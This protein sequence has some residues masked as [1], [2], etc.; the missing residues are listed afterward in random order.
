MSKPTVQVSDI[1]LRGLR[2]TIFL[3]LAAFTLA[4][5]L[6][7]L[8]T[9]LILFLSEPAQR[10]F[11]TILTGMASL[12]SFFWAPLLVFIF[13]DY[14]GI[15]PTFDDGTWL[16]WCL[17]LFA[18]V[19]RPWATLN[20]VLYETWSASMKSRVLL[21]ARA[22]GIRK[23]Q[24]VFSHGLRLSLVTFIQ[25]AGQIFLQVIV[26]SFVVEILLGINGLAN[27]LFKGLS[28]RDYTVV[29]GISLTYCIFSIVITQTMEI[30]S[31]SFDPRW[32]LSHEQ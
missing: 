6:S 22:K 1:I 26:G 16:A 24:I 21:F 13:G 20:L 14:L 18:I 25:K 10:K 19:V 7:L 23:F 29:V 15:F 8:V 28:Q 3:N 32:E 11:V 27:I 30:L 31:R 2:T 17:P 9:G 4:V 5:T 12:P